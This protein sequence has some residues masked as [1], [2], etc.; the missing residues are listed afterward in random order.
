M[1]RQRTDTQTERWRKVSYDEVFDKASAE[2]H[3]QNVATEIITW[4]KEGQT[5]TGVVRRI[6][7]F[8]DGKFDSEALKYTLDTDNGPVS[9]V[10][11]AATDKRL[12]GGLVDGA[13]VRIVYRGQKPLEGGQR[14]NLF[15]VTVATEKEGK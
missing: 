7:P 11:G 15:T 12:G 3:V 14:V 8:T 2:G 9:L 5:V 6:D 13:L 10:L 1:G 4:E